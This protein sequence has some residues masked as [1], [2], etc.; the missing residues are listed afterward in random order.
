MGQ[1]N[2]LRAI[3]RKTRAL[4]Y[5]TFPVA[6]AQVGLCRTMSYEAAVQGLIPVER[7][8]DKLLLVPR[9]SWDR[10]VKRLQLETK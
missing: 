9:K 7:V 6:G 2:K 1:L 10:Q 4:F 5:Y 8:S 3:S